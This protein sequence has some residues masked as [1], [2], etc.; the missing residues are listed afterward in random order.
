MRDEYNFDCCGR[1]IG[2]EP[3]YNVGDSF[4]VILYCEDHHIEKEKND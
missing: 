2:A 1:V 4:D 3:V